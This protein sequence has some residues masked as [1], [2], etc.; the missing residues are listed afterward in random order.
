MLTL[1]G[2]KHRFLTPSLP[3]SHSLV[4]EQNG[5]ASDHSLTKAVFLDPLGGCFAFNHAAHKT[6]AAVSSS[7]LSLRDLQID[8]AFDSF[9]LENT[10]GLWLNIVIMEKL[11]A[12]GSR[13][14][15][16]A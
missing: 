15:E 9:A 7:I 12:S 1:A 13:P 3:S 2:L 16:Q 11:A 6:H 4:F 10:P 14:L 5:S 8:S